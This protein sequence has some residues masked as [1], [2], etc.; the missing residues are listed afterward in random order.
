MIKEHLS[1]PTP[2]KSASSSSVCQ[3]LKVPSCGEVRKRL[4]E[5]L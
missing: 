2:N 1:L 3:P 4:D 5:E